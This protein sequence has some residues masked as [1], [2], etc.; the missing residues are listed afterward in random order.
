MYAAMFSMFRASN[1]S[2]NAFVGNVIQLVLESR[3]INLTI[4]RTQCD[5]KELWESDQSAWPLRF[6]FTGEKMADDSPW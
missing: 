6:T 1:S 4:F 5:C 3:S 2:S